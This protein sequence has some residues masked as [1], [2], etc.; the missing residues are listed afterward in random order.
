MK[1]SE[2]YWQTYKET[3]ADAEVPSHRLLL[4]AGFLNKTTGGIYSYLPMA[5]KVIQKIKTIVREELDNI[6]GQELLMSFVTPAE[7]WKSSGRWTSMGPE[8]IRLKDRKDAEFCLSATNEETITD[9]F[10]NTVNSYKQ[11]PVNLYQINTKFRDEIRPRFGILRG[12]EFIMKDA[13]TFHTDKE[14]M[15]KMYDKYFNAYSEIYKRMGLEFIAVEADGGNMADAGS[16]THEFQVIADTG[17]DDI[18]TAKEIGY[19]ANIETAATVRA[20]LE[21]SGSSELT[22]VKTKDLATCEAVAK[23]LNIP[24]HQ[25]LKTLVY[26]ATYAKKDGTTKQAH[27]LLMILGDDEANEVKL[28]NYFKGAVQVV[29]TTEE[30]LKELNL[31]KGYMSPLGKEG[32]SVILDSAIDINAGYVVGANK[33]DFHTKGFTPS[34]DIKEFKQAD[35]RLTK[36]TDFAP[37]GKT[38]IQFRKGIEAGQIFQLGSKYTK[39]MGATVLDQKGKKVNPMMGCYGIGISR[40]LAAAVEQHHDEDG[41]IWPATIAPFDI[42]F[43]VIGKKD[44]TM[45]FSHELYS[46]LKAN[47]FDV[48]LDDRGMGPGGM[49]KDADLLGLPIRLLL[50]ERDFEASGELEIKIRKTGEVIKV[51]KENLTSKLKEVLSSLGKNI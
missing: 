5:T 46:D 21:F 12:R 40:T 17:E 16:K 9:I 51:S 48:L 13:Y 1:L 43:A 35:I 33:I 32:I 50:G 30:I 4:R 22:D 27:Y 8:M 7:L 26:T 44:S 11:L 24:V 6:G 41:I 23:L 49:F 37:D 47:G 3:P 14:C 2:A 45:Q 34:R 20:G 15:D 31:P 10:K 42:Y 19:A 29:A 36:T 38:P 39:S 25:T 18:I 28:A